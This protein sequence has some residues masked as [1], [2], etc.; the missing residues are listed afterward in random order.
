MTATV[1]IAQLF[2]MMPDL[3]RAGSTNNGEHAGPCPFCGGDDRFRFWPRHPSGQARYW[4]R[5]CEKTGDDIDLLRELKG[6][7]YTEAAAV[8]GRPSLT[9]STV[10]STSSVRPYESPTEPPLAAWQLQ[11]EKVAVEAE[12]AL[13][14]PE[15]ASALEYLRGRG[16]TDKT[17]QEARLGW[18]GQD[19][20]E[21]AQEWGLP[22]DHTPVWLPR[23]VSIP[24]R[25]C[26]FL[27]RLNIRRLAGDPK[28][29]GPAGRRNGLYGADGMRGDKPA[30][31]VEG[32]LDALSVAQEAGDLVNAV[33]TGSTTGSRHSR[34]E[35]LL[36]AAPT[37][38]VA[39]DS[40]D[41]GEEA[42]TYWLDALPGSRRLL[43]ET[44]AAWML[45]AGRDIHAWVQAALNRSVHPTHSET[46]P[47]G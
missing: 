14:R 22:V 17:V 25:S 4:C 3:R 45:E 18:I 42:S 27:W 19:N 6:L 40:D 44:D 37:V 33:A 28:Y 24:W 8:V 47:H 12:A 26:G 29:I 41:P 23:G 2:E 36:R 1:A 35:R 13:W 32:E 5:R 16:F 10:G 30:L 43:P 34:W 39:F 7:S 31:L 9:N 38:F 21:S 11:A 15:G 46:E 20:R